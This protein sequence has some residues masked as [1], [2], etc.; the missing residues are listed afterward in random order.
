MSPPEDWRG[1][2]K[3]GCL[4]SSD[5]VNKECFL[6]DWDHQGGFLDD[7]EAIYNKH[8]LTE[9]LGDHDPFG[10]R[11][12]IITFPKTE[13]NKANKKVGMFF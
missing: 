11:P 10:W 1:R 2:Q 6:S 9:V 8:T 5:A 7:G 4:S 12:L 3:I 13:K